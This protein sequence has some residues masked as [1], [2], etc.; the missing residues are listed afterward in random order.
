MAR[1]LQSGVRRDVCVVL[2]GAE[3][4]RLE[5]LKTRLQQHYDERLE[6]ERFRR[7][8]EKLVDA[9]HVQRRTEGIHDVYLLTE[10][11]EEALEAH[12]E[13]MQEETGL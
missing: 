1:W 4:L 6:P 11:G 9:G 2:Y 7:R 12:V 5:E 3:E 13:W 10:A 8:V